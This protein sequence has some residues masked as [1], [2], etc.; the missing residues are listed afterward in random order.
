M[1]DDVFA[2]SKQSVRSETQQDFLL[3]EM[4]WILNDWLIMC[5]QKRVRGLLKEYAICS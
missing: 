1:Q 3:P 2:M 4:S 5:H